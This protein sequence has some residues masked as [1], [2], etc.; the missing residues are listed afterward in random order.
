[1]EITKNKLKTILTEQKESYQLIILE[2][3]KKPERQ[4]AKI[5]EML[6]GNTGVQNKFLTPKNNKQFLI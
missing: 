4:L 2:A 1:M 6:S 5:I 3:F